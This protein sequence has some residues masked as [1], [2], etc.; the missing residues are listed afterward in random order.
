MRRAT[1]VALALGGLLLAIQAVPYGRDHDNPK[2]EQEPAWDSPATRALAERACF[3]CH[4]H[5]T[6]WPWYS[7][8]APV[9]WVVQRHVDEGREH[10]NFS[11]WGTPSRHAKEAAEEVEEGEMP[12]R[13]YVALHPAA[14]LSPA[15]K[16]AL[17]AGLKATFGAAEP[18]Q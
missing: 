2:V 13:G 4:S 7:H 6:R 16:A 3:D 10:L 18:G 15:D 5:Q 12:L 14:Q 1:Q 11:T 9:S 8:V 17:V